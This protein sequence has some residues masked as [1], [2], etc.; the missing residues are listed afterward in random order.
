MIPWSGM[1]AESTADAEKVVKEA[2]EAIKA[3][4]EYT[5]QQE[6][7]FQRT[8]HKELAAVLR[9]IVGLR[10]KIAKASD[11]PRADLQ[12]SLNELEEKMVSGKRLSELK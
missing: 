4:K 6:E 11:S 5:A 1:A 7:D 10:D 3:I 9:Q 8:T 2:Q 12:K